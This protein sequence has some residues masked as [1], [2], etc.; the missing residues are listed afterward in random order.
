MSFKEAVQQVSV[1][2]PAKVNLHLSVLG[3]RS[4]N[5]HEI[6]SVLAKLD[7]HDIVTVKREGRKIHCVVDVYQRMHWTKLKISRKSQLKPGE[8]ILAFRMVLK[9]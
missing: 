4:D 3:R 1:P 2:A 5:F 7:L 8:S 9:L 6:I